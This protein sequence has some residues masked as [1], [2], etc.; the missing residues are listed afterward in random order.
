MPS[1]EEIRDAWGD[2]AKWSGGVDNGDG[3]SEA[4]GSVEM[5]WYGSILP[6][7]QKFLPNKVKNTE[8]LL[9]I[10]PGYGRWTQFLINKFKTIYL[11]DINENCITACKKRFYDVDNISYFVNDGKDLS[12][13]P[14][15]SVDFVFSF[16]SG[17]C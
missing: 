9:E 8:V 1:L 12:M 14:D 13:I 4:W 16:D 10:A 17:A 5:Q 7:I 11:V 2:D 6:R 15:R 3:W